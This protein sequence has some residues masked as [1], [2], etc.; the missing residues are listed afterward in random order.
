MLKPPLQS[1]AYILIAFKKMKT[2]IKC[3]KNIEDVEL[4]LQ[5][6]EDGIVKR[7]SGK[8]EEEDKPASRKQKRNDLK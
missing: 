5:I 4:I 8:K 3:S 2:Y 1:W 6:R 7:M